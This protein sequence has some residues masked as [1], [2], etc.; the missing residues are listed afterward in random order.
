M[1][2]FDDLFSS[3]RESSLINRF[4]DFFKPRLKSPIAEQRQPNIFEKARAKLPTFLW[5]DQEKPFQ[6]K[7][8]PTPTPTSFPSPTPTVT[9]TPTPTVE[10][11]PTLVPETEKYVAPKWKNIV[12]RFFPNKEVNNALNVILRESSGVETTIHPN[13]D[14]SKDY[15]LFQINDIH[16]PKIKKIFGYDMEDLLDPVK[17]MEVASWLWKKQGWIPWY[18]ARSLGLAD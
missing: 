4:T 1:A 14:G 10:P 7:E 9:P 17:N 12:S 11:T 5:A 6:E 13:S 8:T 18:G 3:Q 2:L 16:A 15:G